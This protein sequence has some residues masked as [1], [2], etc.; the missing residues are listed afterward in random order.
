M[1]YRF[2]TYSEKAANLEQF[3]FQ[4]IITQLLTVVKGYDMSDPASRNCFN[5]LATNIFQDHEIS[6][7][8]A[9]IIVDILEI[10]K[11]NDQQRSCYLC[12][13]ITNV[14]NGENSNYYKGLRQKDEEKRQKVKLKKN[15]NFL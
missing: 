11:P 7:D 14:M 1:F 5:L 10:T 12:E 15:K 8:T 2:F 4:F 9:Q 13:I 6:I 3:H